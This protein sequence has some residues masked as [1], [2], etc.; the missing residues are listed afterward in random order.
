MCWLS[1]N[2]GASTSWNPQGLSRPVMWLL[3]L[4]T[5]DGNVSTNKCAGFVGFLPNRSVKSKRQS[6]KLCQYCIQWAS[7]RYPTVLYRYCETALLPQRGLIKTN[8]NTSD[9]VMNV[10]GEGSVVPSVQQKSS[11][12][13]FST[14]RTGSHVTYSCHHNSSRF[15][16][17]VFVH[18][19]P[20]SVFH[21]LQS[22]M[23]RIY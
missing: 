14:S 13:K 19:W 22:I 12:L 17:L 1:W 23:P 5:P 21:S 9:Y 2:L 15:T 8:A 20:S 6:L 3:Y 10:Y 4:F 16:F 7:Q 11:G 18:S